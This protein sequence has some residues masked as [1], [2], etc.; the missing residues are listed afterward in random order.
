[1]L[2]VVITGEVKKEREARVR[3]LNFSI[4]VIHASLRPSHLISTNTYIILNIK[5]EQPPITEYH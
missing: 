3:Y 5:Q 4:T 1:M 2:Y